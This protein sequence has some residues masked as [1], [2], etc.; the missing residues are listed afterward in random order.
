M[1]EDAELKLITQR[2]L[3]QMKR[4]AATTTSAKTQKVEKTG[5]QVVTEMLIDRG[6]EVLEAAYSYYP[7]ETDH[8]VKELSRLI[9]EGKFNEKISGGELYSL[10]RNLGLRFKLNTSMKVEEKG[11]LIDIGEKFRLRRE[12]EEKA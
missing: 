11:R 6:D 12:G 9:R 10:F 8:I 5:R 2:K 7:N 4:M 1:E 3:A